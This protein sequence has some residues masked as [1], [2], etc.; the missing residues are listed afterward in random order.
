MRTVNMHDAKSQLSKLVEQALSGEDVVIAK[1]GVPAV[2]LVPVQRG[3][4]DRKPGRFRG[5]ITLA[6][7]F[8]ETPEEV[9][10]AFEGSA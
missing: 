6:P 5:E 2:R 9:I 10:T 8:D 1:A 7:D 4:V 3:Q